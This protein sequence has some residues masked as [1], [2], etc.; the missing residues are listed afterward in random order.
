MCIRDRVTTLKMDLVISPH[1][2]YDASNK[3][4]H[5][6]EKEYMTAL[7]RNLNH[8]FVRRIHVLTLSAEEVAQ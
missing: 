2:D 7:Q 1:F 6:R 4:L 5:E 3:G 8:D